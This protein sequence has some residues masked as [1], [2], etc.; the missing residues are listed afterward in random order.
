MKNCFEARR[1][2]ASC[3]LCERDSALLPA[4]SDQGTPVATE[5]PPL[6][7]EGKQRLMEWMAPAVKVGFAQMSQHLIQCHNEYIL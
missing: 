6:P 5:L 7:S 2:A 3:C 4:V 1:A